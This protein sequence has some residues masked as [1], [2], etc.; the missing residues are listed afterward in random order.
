MS[1]AMRDAGVTGVPELCRRAGINPSL[2]SRWEHHE[3]Q[4]GNRALRK[5]APVLNVSVRKLLVEAG[6]FSEHEMLGGEDALSEILASPKLTDRQ[7]LALLSEW[8]K[9][10]RERELRF[11]DTVERMLAW[12]G[13]SE[14]SR[15]SP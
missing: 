3:R 2:V 14:E 10:E 12:A 11:S 9:Q 7:K 15:Q 6:H 8:R 13:R 1:E 5:L 4:P